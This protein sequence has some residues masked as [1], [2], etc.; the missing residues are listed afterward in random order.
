MLVRTQNISDPKWQSERE[1]VMNKIMLFFQIK[2]TDNKEA[3]GD[4]KK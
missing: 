3:D 2:S 1:H 4:I